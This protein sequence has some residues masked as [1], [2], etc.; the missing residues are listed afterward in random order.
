MT[1]HDMA[2]EPPVG[3]HRT[4]QIYRL[5]GTSRRQR[6]HTRGFRPDVHIDIICRDANHRQAYPVHRKAVARVQFGGESRLENQAQ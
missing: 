3:A 2:A 4:L 1:L 6:R 5:T